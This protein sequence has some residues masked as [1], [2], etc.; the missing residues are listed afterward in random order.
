MG[1]EVSSG[2]RRSASY[3]L[4]TCSDTVRSPRCVRPVKG[5]ISLGTRIGLVDDLAIAAALQDSAKI[6]KQ[7]IDALL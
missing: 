3:L 6:R 2:L 4:Q 1:R 5:C 7:L